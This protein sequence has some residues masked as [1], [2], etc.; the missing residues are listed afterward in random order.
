MAKNKA[1]VTKKTIPLPPGP[2]VSWDDQAA[3]KQ[4]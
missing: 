1:K 4:I 2:E 3:E